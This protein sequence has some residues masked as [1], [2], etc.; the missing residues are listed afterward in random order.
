MT[1]ADLFDQFGRIRYGVPT[2]EKERMALTGELPGSPSAA[3]ADPLEA[4]R[5]ASGYLFAKQHPALAE[6]VQPV[7]DRVRIGWF[8][9]SPEL[10]SYAQAGANAARIHEQPKRSSL[11]TLLGALAVR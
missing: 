8:G 2:S 10:Q 11:A 4:E 1:L 9:D 3:K 7:V 6:V 5:Y